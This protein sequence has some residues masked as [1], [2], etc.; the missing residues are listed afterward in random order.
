MMLYYVINVCCWLL[1]IIY[2]VHCSNI[3]VVLLFCY[4]ISLSCLDFFVSGAILCVMQVNKIS[5]KK[6]FPCLAF[7]KK[8]L[9]S[10]IWHKFVSSELSLYYKLFIFGINM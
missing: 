8:K 7:Y 2:R 4:C 6:N 9:V 5:K 3:V 10:G 1:Y